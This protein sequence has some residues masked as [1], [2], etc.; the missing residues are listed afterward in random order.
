MLMSQTLRIYIA[1]HGDASLSKKKDSLRPLSS[2]GVKEVEKVARWASR[3]GI[4]IEQIRHSGLLRAQESA[5]IFAK[6]LHPA[7]GVQSVHGLKPNDTVRSMAT[8]LTHET[9]T[10]LLVGHLPFMGLLAE[11]LIRGN[12]KLRSVGFPTGGL[13]GFEY[14]GEKW[15]L[16][17]TA[18]PDK[19]E[20]GRD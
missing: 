18:T 14:D 9:K 6:H 8:D 15:T 1:R 4:K 7:A 20:S 17:C 2:Q 3:Q 16:I 19:V 13:A 12:E 5:E 11:E 10:L